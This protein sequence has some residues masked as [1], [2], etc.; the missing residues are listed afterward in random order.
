MFLGIPI[1]I[2]D[3]ISIQV[4]AYILIRLHSIIEL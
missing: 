3:E 4:F 2:F 1:E